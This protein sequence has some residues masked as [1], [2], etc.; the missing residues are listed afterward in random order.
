MLSF[1]VCW[2]EV[3]RL[4]RYNYSVGRAHRCDFCCPSE[5]LQNTFLSVLTT[6]LHGSH[7]RQANK[8]GFT[9]QS[10]SKNPS[11]FLIR[12]EVVALAQP[13]NKPWEVRNNWTDIKK[14]MYWQPL[15]AFERNFNAVAAG[16]FKLCIACRRW[17]ICRW[18]LRTIF[19]DA[20]VGDY[21]LWCKEMLARRLR[22]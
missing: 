13:I 21:Q 7:R 1:H 8:S 14:Q 11:C 20:N 15:V 12:E 10:C 17:W 22:K 3:L 16:A 4:G 2:I 9:Y 19:V 5:F 18:C 6:P